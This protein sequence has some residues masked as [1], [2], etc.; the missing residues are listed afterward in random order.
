MNLFFALLSS[1]YIAG[2][3]LLAE[4]PAKSE[5]IQK[6]NP[7][8]L[9]HVPLYGVLTWLL[10]LT[11]RPRIARWQKISFPL[12]ISF[13][14]AILDEINQA[15]IPGREASVGNVLLDVIGIVFVIIILL[16]RSPLRHHPSCQ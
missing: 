6:F 9:A 13:L 12:V 11:F 16:V 7:Y 5:L 8:S 3:F 14:V 2:I 10:V 4:L 15:C 1:I